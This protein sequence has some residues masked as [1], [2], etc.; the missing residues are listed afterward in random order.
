MGVDERV[1]GEIEEDEL[2]LMDVNQEI[3]STLTE[4]LNCESVRGDRKYRR[5]IQTRLMDAERELKGG[6]N[7]NHGGRRDENFGGF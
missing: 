1:L 3:K 2:K 4:L 7:Q 5:W 6:K